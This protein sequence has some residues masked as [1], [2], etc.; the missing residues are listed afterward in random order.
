MECIGYRCR[1]ESSSLAGL[2]LPRVPE[3]ID[4]DDL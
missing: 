3:G 4:V 1:G 2:V